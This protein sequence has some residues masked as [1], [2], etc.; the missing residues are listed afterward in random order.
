MPEQFV[1]LRLHTE[2]SIVDGLVRIDELV[3]SAA[4]MQMPAVALTDHSNLFGL[5]KFYTAAMRSG[6]K[7][8]CGCDVLVEN[9][10][11]PQ[12]PCP[13][14]LLVRNKVGYRNLTELI[15]RAYTEKSTSSLL[16]VRRE[17]VAQHSEGLIAL[18]AGRRDRSSP[19]G[20][21]RGQSGRCLSAMDGLVS[22]Q[23]L[24][25]V[26]SLWARRRGAL[27]R[28]RGHASFED[29]LPGGGH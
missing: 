15:S 4:A 28:C 6:I 21:W 20:G 9:E 18:S 1:H 10:E 12:R 26:A 25:G 14:V 7:P 2:Y 13:L 27:H 16:T 22:R 24:Y 11:N 8:I 3:K 23:F 29:G 5:I 19:V 17:W